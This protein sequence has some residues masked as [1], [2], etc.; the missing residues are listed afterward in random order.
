MWLYGL[1]LCG[2][3]ASLKQSYNSFKS[4]RIP[5]IQNEFSKFLDI[6]VQKIQKF[7]RFNSSNNGSFKLSKLRISEFLE[8]T[9]SSKSVEICEA[10]IY[11]NILLDNDLEDS[12]IFVK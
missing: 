11:E 2:Y 9:Q 8:H 4:F 6:K 7:Q 10:H 3:V 1:R 12:C 5:E